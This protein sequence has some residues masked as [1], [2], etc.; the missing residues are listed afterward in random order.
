M[1]RRE[2]VSRFP[3]AEPG[4]TERSYYVADTRREQQKTYADQQKRPWRCIRH[5]AKS[6]VLSPD[7]LERVTVMTADR[8]R[9]SPDRRRPDEEP[10]FL[11]GLFWG[12]G[13]GFQHGPGFKAWAKDFP[14]GTRLIVT[15]RIELP[16]PTE[17]PGPAPILDND[18][19][20]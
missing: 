18:P 12:G 8:L 15:A 17:E 13:S 1:S 9:Q 4:C 16:E 19:P 3:C 11:D 20:F 2:Y 5:T 6:E 10:P 14:P 7:N